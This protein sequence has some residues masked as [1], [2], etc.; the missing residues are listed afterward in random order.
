[1]GD[2]IIDD[3]GFEGV[4]APYTRWCTLITYPANHGSKFS[5]QTVRMRGDGS[6]RLAEMRRDWHQANG[7][8]AV[9][10][11]QVWTPDSWTDVS[12]GGEAGSEATPKDDLRGAS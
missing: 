7:A 5:G 4:D 1:M 6:R 3:G 12:E 2:E 9:L 8:T 11:R 10:Q